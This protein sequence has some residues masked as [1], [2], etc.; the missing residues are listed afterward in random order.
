MKPLN[1]FKN[2][3]MNGCRPKRDGKTRSLFEH[4]SESSH[5]SGLYYRKDGKPR[6][7]ATTNFKRSL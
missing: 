5:R 4:G 7:L 1:I 2:Q 6:T 3:L